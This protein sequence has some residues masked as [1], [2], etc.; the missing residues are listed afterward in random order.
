MTDTIKII[1]ADDHHL[2]REGIRNFLATQ[3]D[4]DIVAEAGDAAGAARLC[5]N[6]QPQV[7]LIDLMMPGGGVSATREIRNTCPSTQVIILTSFEDDQ[8][9][10]QAMDAGALS[11][12]LKDVDAA[13]LA[14]AVRKAAQNEAVIH[15]RIAQ[16]LKNH[17]RS[18]S[19]T[20]NPEGLSP[21]E[22]EVLEVMAEG[23]TNQQIATHLHIGEKTV[24][25]HVS[26][27]LSKLDVHDRTQAAVYAWKHGLTG[28]KDSV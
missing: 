8:L 25:S 14:A 3:D 13:I 28:K 2:V 16:R 18:G 11:Y 10:H 20:D 17:A 5:A 9:I 26:N 19:S 12:L 7:A 23:M 4:F 15:P 27:I 22:Q 1:I 21:R 24:K 6:H